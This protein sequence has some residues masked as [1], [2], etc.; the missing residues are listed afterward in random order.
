M[1]IWI[2]VFLFLG[3]IIYPIVGIVSDS[4]SDKA[5][6]IRRKKYHGEKEL[7]YVTTYQNNNLSKEDM[8]NLFLSQFHF[9]RQ[10]YFVFN[11]KVFSDKDKQDYAWSIKTTKQ[12]YGWGVVYHLTFHF[13]NG[14]F[15]I[16][17]SNNQFSSEGKSSEK[18]YYFSGHDYGTNK[19][20][21]ALM[22]CKEEAE[23][24]WKINNKDINEDEPFNFIS[25][26][27]NTKSY[28]ENTRKQKEESSYGN[29]SI[30]PDLINFYRKLLGLKL[31]FSQKELKSAYHEAVGKYHPDRYGTSSS[32]DRE[33]AEM[34]MKQVNEAYEKL[35]EIAV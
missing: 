31:C 21:T 12:T 25:L 24:M 17:F 29:S 34:L 2:V 8:M 22:T 14:W 9:Y 33:N 30:P 28:R 18:Y 20:E 11:Y 5:K 35:K 19:I 10:C 3:P 27:N 1:W 6:E 7:I 16:S 26:I 4:V 32:R 13:S 23:I 15:L